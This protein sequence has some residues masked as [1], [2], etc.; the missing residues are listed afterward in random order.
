LLPDR[1]FEREIEPLEVECCE[2]EN[3]CQWSGQLRKYKEHRDKCHSATCQFCG[4]QFSS[5]NILEKHKKRT[6]S[7]IMRGDLGSHLLTKQ[8]Q[9]ALIT[10]L[11]ELKSK[12]NLLPHGDHNTCVLTTNTS[13]PSSTVVKQENMEP[14]TMEY[15]TMESEGLN[16]MSN[17]TSH[18]S[19]LIQTNELYDELK[20]Y[21][22]TLMILSQGI[23]TLSNDSSRLNEELSH[24]NNLIQAYSVKP[25]GHTATTL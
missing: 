19:T 12:M 22:N 23:Q 18:T 17:V 21:Q 11:K 9:E 6:C 3:N 4:E 10:F 20:K 7:K 24:V 14:H 25:R 1:G 15:E 8:H 5:F 16:A 13:V 2:K